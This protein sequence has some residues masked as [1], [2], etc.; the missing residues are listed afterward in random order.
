MLKDCSNFWIETKELKRRVRDII[1]PNRDLGHVDRK[2]AKGDLPAA[3]H[4]AIKSEVE[5][6]DNNKPA[7]HKS[8]PSE[9]EKSPEVSICEDCAQVL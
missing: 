7:Q 5:E 2:K 3:E 9:V 8:I 6:A 4:T 1:E